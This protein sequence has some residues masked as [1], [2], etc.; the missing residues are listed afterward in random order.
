MLKSAPKNMNRSAST[1]EGVCPLRPGRRLFRASSALLPAAAVLALLLATPTAAGQEVKDASPT[2]T[3]SPTA[4]EAAGSTPQVKRSEDMVV[5]ATRSERST[6]DIP[7]SVSV[8]TEEQLE[9]SPTRTLDDALRTVVGL[10]LP[11]GNSDIIQPTTNNVSMRGLG[12]NRA[13]VLLD[14]VPQNDAAGGYIHWNK[15]PLAD[16]ERVEVARG[17]ASSLFGNYA[18]G[19]VVNIITRPLEPGRVTA[20]ASYGSFNTFRA[21]ASAADSLG[22]GLDL[23]VFANYEN[24]DG[25]NRTLP[26]ER[27]AIDI[28]S[29]S[30]T[31]NLMTKLD[32]KTASGVETFVK[33]G[34]TDQY[35][36]QGTPL[37]NNDQRIYDISGG[38]RFPL[39]ASV[40]SASAFYQDVR[41]SLYSSTLVP[42]AG[43]D[44]EYPSQVSQQPGWNLGGSLQWSKPLTGLVKFLTFGLDLQKVTSE[45]TSQGYSMTGQP[46]TFRSSQGHQTFEGVFGEASF[47]PDPRFEALLS[48]RVDFWQNAGGQEYSSTGNVTT[49]YPDRSAT[50]FDPRL[51]LRWAESDE[52]AV[53]G[54]VYRAFHAPNLRDLY[55]SSLQRTLQTLANPN[56]GPETLTGGDAGLDLKA[57][58]F[59]G[60]L[61]YF[62]NEVQGLIARKALATTPILVVQ[63]QNIGKARAQ[64][65]EVFGTFQLAKFLSLDLGYAFNDSVVTDNPADPSIVGKQ[66]PDVPRNSGSLSLNWTPPWGLVVTFRGRAQSQRYADDANLLATDS[67]VVFDFFVSYPVLKTFEIFVSG[68]NIFNYEYISE[69]NIGR[70]LGQPQAFFGGLR[71]RLPLAPFGAGAP[72]S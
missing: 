30:R 42:G 68:E 32:Y 23:G 57:G 11:L 21:G 18:M 72:K 63:P 54:A 35:M 13:L 65:V 19:G 53:R 2:P 50:R 28:A 7:V 51:S 22:G 33:G 17:A 24:T 6:A 3:P 14:G 64:G 45:N 36:G 62:Y 48:A 16:I 5:T 38:A 55:R 1:P 46:T 31:F 61:N 60:Q 49:T 34:V 9:Q 71:F 59:T 69:V 47:V 52:L 12:G 8:V 10:N 27:G 41:Y 40:L 20:D 39:G 56:L 43:R 58:I 26:E 44:R 67:S 15:M 66:L 29:G 37:S 25:Y 70:R 4:S